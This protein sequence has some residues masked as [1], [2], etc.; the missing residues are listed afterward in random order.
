MHQRHVRGRDGRRTGDDTGITYSYKPVPANGRPCLTTNPV[1]SLIDP[2]R[3]RCGM[4]FTGYSGNGDPDATIVASLRTLSPLSFLWYTVYETEDT[5]HWGQ[6]GCDRMYYAHP[7]PPSSCYIYW[8]TG[9]EM[10]GPMYTQDQFLVNS[11][12]SPQFGRLG[13]NDPIASEVPTSNSGEDICVNSDCS[14]AHVENPEPNV[15]NQVQ[16]PSDN[17]N[18]LT[19]ATT[20][21][22][23][24]TGTVTLTLSVDPSTGHTMANGW[25]CPGSTASASCTQISSFDLTAKPI[26]YADNGTGCSGAYDPTNVTYSTNSHSAYY[27]PC[28]DIYIQGVYSTGLTVAAANNIIVT[29]NL[30]NSTDPNGLT[31][32]DGLGDPGSG[33]RQVRPRHARLQRQPGDDDRRRHPHAGPLVLRRQ[34]RLRRK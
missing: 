22:V 6:L 23:V 3:A 34:L 24:W 9:D 13:M 33:G 11:G 15:Q 25:N 5:D 26:I 28:G 16:L 4:E 7:Q 31:A 1:G 27:G 19:D 10:N 32:A 20:H 21:G 18:L 2:P 29:A 12:D 30:L 14:N 8:V 17:A